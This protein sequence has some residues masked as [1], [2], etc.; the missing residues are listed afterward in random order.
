MDLDEARR[1]AAW[2]GMRL[3]TAEEWVA[4][5][6]GPVYAYPYPWGHEDR[7]ALANTLELGLARPCRVGTFPGGDSPFGI[8]DLLG[9]VWEWTD[10][11]LP[12]AEPSPSSADAAILGGS[13]LTWRRRMFEGGR[14][15]A[16]PRAARARGS[17][18]GLRCAVAAEPY[19]WERAGR[20]L[21]GDDAR[22]R[23]L[24][25]G[26]RWGRSAIG[27]LERLCAREEAPAGLALLLEGA[28][29]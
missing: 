3:L 4:V 17:D 23:L 7:A 14:L 6:L 20:W 1:F 28:R 22:D 29:R 9:N 11:P 16:Q 8:S 21:D 15:L 26:A 18:V 10:A 2:R 5:A 19:L 27:L 25:I 12:G 24:A 13:F